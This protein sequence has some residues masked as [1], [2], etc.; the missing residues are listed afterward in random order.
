MHARSNARRKASLNISYFAYLDLRHKP[1]Q[2]NSEVTLVVE[3]VKIVI[4]G[5]K[6][7]IPPGCSRHIDQLG[8][9]FQILFCQSNNFIN[10]K[11][12]RYIIGLV[13]D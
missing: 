9:F 6:A 7:R 4:I 12:C 3:V 10:F 13:Q 2:E 1:L 5:L 8:F 11:S